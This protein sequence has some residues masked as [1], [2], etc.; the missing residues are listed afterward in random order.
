MQRQHITARIEGDLVKRLDIVATTTNTSRAT[1]IEEAVK[2]YLNDE[3]PWKTIIKLLNRSKKDH[4]DLTHTVHTLSAATERFI[5]VAL[6][7]WE[8]ESKP[9]YDEP[10]RAILDRREAKMQEF[11]HAVQQ[12]LEQDGTLLER[13]TQ[14]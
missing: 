7:N 4:E 14:A 3:P 5:R 12:S 10:D 9:M 2:Q 11:Y 13:V 1:L 8:L 6:L